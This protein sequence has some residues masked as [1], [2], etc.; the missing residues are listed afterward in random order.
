[1]KN[2][3]YKKIISFIKARFAPRGAR[4][5]FS[6]CGEDIIMSDILAEKGIRKVS[7]IDIGAHH[8]VFGNNTYL[9]YK[10]GGQGVL[11]EPNARLCQEI[12]RKRPRDFV[13]NGGVGPKDTEAD[14]YAFERSTRSTFLDAQAKH[15]EA[16]SGQKPKVEKKTV[17]SLD[18]L[19]R[20]YFHSGAP[21]VVSIDAEGYDVE[22][23][24]G[25]S[26]EKRPKV[27]CVESDKDGGSGKEIYSVMDR[28][29]YKLAAQTRNNSIFVDKQI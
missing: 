2:N 8:P 9:L 17:L 10:K 19:I 20:N 14:F 18:T 3:F 26:W 1:M 11:V 12:V 24:G 23:L 21:D 5:I 7:Y 4:Q 15:W 16:E 6:T 27:F 13:I 29:G 25:F 22:I 28:H